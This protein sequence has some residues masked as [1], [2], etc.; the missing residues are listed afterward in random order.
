MTSSIAKITSK[1]SPLIGLLSIQLLTGM[2]LMPLMNF[3]SIYLNEVMHYSLQEVAIVIA[4]GQVVGMV[5]SIVGGSLS[6]RNGHKWILFWG[7]AGI[8]ISSLLYIVRVPSIVII[9]WCLTQ[10]GNGL[11]VVAGQGY[12][13]LASSA[14]ILGLVSAFYNW[15]YTI[16]GAVGIPLAT[17]IL[18]DDDFTML[19]F[20]LLGFGVFAIGIASLLPRMRSDDALVDSASTATSRVGYGVLLRRDIILLILLRFL[21]TCFYGITTLLPLVIKQQS[22]SNAIVAAY[23]TGSSVFATL[24]QLVA[25]RAADKY[26]VKLPTQISFSVIL[27]AI[28]GLIITGESLWGLFIFGSLGVGAAWALSTLLPGMVTHTAEPAIR[29][30]V[31]GSL[32][33]IWTL[34]MAIGTLLGGSLIDISI[35]LPFIVVGVLNLIALGLTV[36]FFQMTAQKSATEKMI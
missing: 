13:T 18:G 12:L 3:G 4:L 27:F 6:D 25:G 7:V 17:L 10:A 29:G 15:G 22:G 5:A 21:P 2:M 36:P 35:G 28:L 8:A 24:A 1:H 32:H 33:L 19:G 11:A 23:V 16:G 31:F 30:R 9:L 14:S 34:A 20:A 26:G